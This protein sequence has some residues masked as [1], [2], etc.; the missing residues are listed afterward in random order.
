[1]TSW[2]NTAANRDGLWR[3]LIP[4]IGLDVTPWRLA[5]FEEWQRWEG[6]G[7]FFNPLATTQPG[8]EDSTSPYWNTFGPNGQYHVR[9]YA[10]LDAG[11]AALAATIKNGYYPAL[12]DALQRQ[13]LDGPSQVAANIDTWGTSGFA[14]ALRAGWQPAVTVT[15]ETPGGI[16]LGDVANSLNNLNAVV[17]DLRARLEKVEA[18]TGGEVP[19]HSHGGVV[20]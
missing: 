13:V 16:T 9:N 18:G 11:V 8:G 2:Q 15:P 1:M 7:A 19:E 17:I 20:R 12:V 3:L 6:T 10:S 4:A 14:S 5:F